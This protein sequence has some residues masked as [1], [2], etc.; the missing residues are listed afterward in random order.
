M[1]ARDTIE[2]YFT[3]FNAGETDKMLDC[4]ADDIAHHVNEGQVREGKEKFAAFN[5]HMT[6]CYKEELTDMVIFV[7]EDGTRAAAE[8]IVN[9]TYLATDEGLPEAKG[10][11]YRLPA[12]SFFSLR[13]GKIT[14]VVT[15][16]N[17]A[18]WIRQV[19]A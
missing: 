18:D 14:R 11:T 1:S 5:D 7:N 15:Y 8:F 9:G 10:Q 12:G 16:Y 3:A 17:L 6:R 13:D 4:L 2:T 19:S